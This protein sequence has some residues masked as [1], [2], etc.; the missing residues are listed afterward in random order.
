MTPV[1][2]SV[3]A[4]CPKVMHPLPVEAAPHFSSNKNE[5]ILHYECFAVIGIM[6]IF[7]FFFCRNYIVSLIV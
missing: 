4:I 1:N 7:F 5:V 3:M 2:Q 6:W